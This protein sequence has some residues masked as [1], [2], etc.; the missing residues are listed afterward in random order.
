[1]GLYY[2]PSGV[3]RQYSLEAYRSAYEALGYTETTGEDLEPEYQKIALFTKYGVPTH[4]SRQLESGFWT[5]KLGRDVDMKHRLQGVCGNQYGEVA[6]ILR[7]HRQ[8]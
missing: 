2:W 1:M 6:L 5:S 3:T 7:R 8:D 4:A